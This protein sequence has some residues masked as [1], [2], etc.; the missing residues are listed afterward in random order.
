MLVHS[1]LGT[2]GRKWHR[3]GRQEPSGHNLGKR[4]MFGF[5]LM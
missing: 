5:R 1:E 3:D 4:S 2:I